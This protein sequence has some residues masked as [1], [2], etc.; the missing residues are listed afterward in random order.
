MLSRQKSK[1][2]AL[3][4]DATMQRTRLVLLKNG[5]RRWK[6]QTFARPDSLLLVFLAGFA[7]AP[8]PRREDEDDAQHDEP[9]GQSLPIR[10]LETGF[11]AWRLFGNEVRTGATSASTDAG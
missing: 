2:D 11:L 3:A 1:I 5:M 10:A 6:R 4:A 7:L 9:R 8:T